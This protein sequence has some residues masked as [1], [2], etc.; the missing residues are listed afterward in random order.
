MFFC[1]Q[2]CGKLTC[3]CPNVVEVAPKP[4][5]AVDDYAAI[6]IRESELQLEKALAR[7]ARD[8]QSM[9]E[10]AASQEPGGPL[11]SPS[12]PKLPEGRERQ[13]LSEDKIVAPMDDKGRPQ[14]DKARI[15]GADDVYRRINRNALVA[16]TEEELEKGV[17]ITG[18]GGG[19]GREVPKIQWTDDGDL[20]NWSPD[21]NVYA[22]KKPKPKP[23]KPRPPY[24][25]DELHFQMV[26]YGRC[27]QIDDRE[28]NGL[29][30][31][32]CPK[33]L[34]GSDRPV[35]GADIIAQVATLKEEIKD[36][37]PY[38]TY[39]NLPEAIVGVLD[40]TSEGLF[41]KVIDRSDS[42]IC[43]TGKM[44]APAKGVQVFSTEQLLNLYDTKVEFTVSH[45]G[46]RGT[47]I[48]T[49][50]INDETYCGHLELTLDEC[51]TNPPKY[52]MSDTIDQLLR[53]HVGVFMQRVHSLVLDGSAL[54]CA[55]TTAL[56]TPQNE[57]YVGWFKDGKL[58][59]LQQQQKEFN[60][61]VNSKVAENE[62]LY[63]ELCALN[64]SGDAIFDMTELIEG[65]SDG[66]KLEV[67]LKC[68]AMENAIL[69]MADRTDRSEFEYQKVLAERFDA[70]FNGLCLGRMR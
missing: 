18:H 27:L 28:G 6:R 62:R 17:T 25:F 4:I 10:D 30:I 38:V 2:K 61:Y 12:K 54:Q 32:H 60:D 63:K 33:W 15:E 64:D 37:L 59:H 1:C 52:D 51:P 68:R 21:P 67:F 56:S 65:L 22:V 36:I 45:G 31:Q 8:L 19:G 13:K 40:K 9:T 66:D 26:D 34:D 23:G 41:W 35:S 5:A 3:D 11:F 29:V 69:S 20:A 53:E 50:K 57:G 44:H 47:A 49:V 48:L 14:L 58:D 24:K 46:Q 70:I 16:L 7:A 39:S 43:Q 55:F 42:G